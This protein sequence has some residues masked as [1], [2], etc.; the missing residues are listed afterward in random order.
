MKTFFT[1]TM[2]IF[3]AVIARAQLTNTKWQGK[4]KVPD[5]TS[6][7]LD[8]KKDTVNMIIVD[9]DMVGESMTYSVKDSIITMKKT[10]GHSPCNVDDVFKVKYK[11]KDDKLFISNLTDPC[12]ARVESWSTEPF[13]RV[14]Q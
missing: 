4:L 3:T 11:I 13:I 14:K 10:A 7:I 8:F 5:E 12:D 9:Y 6:V 1:L 2:L